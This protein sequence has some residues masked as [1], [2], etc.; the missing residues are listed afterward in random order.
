M[1]IKDIIQYTK[2]YYNIFTVNETLKFNPVVRHEIG[3][4]SINN[5]IYTRE[6]C[7]INE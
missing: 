3:K 4:N 1:N 7:K 6:N 2:Y 5:F